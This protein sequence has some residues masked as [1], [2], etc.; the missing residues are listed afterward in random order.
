MQQVYFELFENVEMYTINIKAE[1]WH[2]SALN[3]C[4][5]EKI[6]RKQVNTDF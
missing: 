6:Q 2:S 4:K 1:V 3:A 5:E